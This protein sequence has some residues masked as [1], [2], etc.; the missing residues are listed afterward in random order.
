MV[1]AK[2]FSSV[3]NYQMTI[4]RGATLSFRKCVTR[5]RYF[6][7]WEMLRIETLNF[8]T[9]NADFFFTICENFYNLFFSQFF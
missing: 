2:L 5:K 8:E 6:Q 1:Q 4:L 7:N 3:I 9:Y